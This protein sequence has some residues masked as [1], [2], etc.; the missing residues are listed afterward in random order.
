MGE[1][2][3]YNILFKENELNEKPFLIN[4]HLEVSFKNFHEIV[5]CISNLFT[6][7]GLL[8]G[9]RVAVQADKNNL[10]LALYV[11]TVKAGGVYLPLN[12]GYTTA[13]LQYFINDAEPKIIIVDNS[14]KESIQTIS[15]GK[16]TFIYTL[17]KDESGTLRENIIGLSKKF[18]PINRDKDD[19]AAILYTSGTTGKSKGAM[20]TLS[21][22]HI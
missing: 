2:Y 12:T 11:A 16:Q 14:K 15:S 21:L 3:L 6:K 22:I 19:L 10:Q 8:P 7:N 17:N 18:T 1:N 4:S 9:D 5:N 20:L 13:E